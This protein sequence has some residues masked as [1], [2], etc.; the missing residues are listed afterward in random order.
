V[1]R[2][3]EVRVSF[4]GVQ[5]LGGVSL[6]AGAGA[7][8][9]LIGPNGA[10]KTTL[11]NVVTGFQ[12]PNRGSVSMD[13]RDITGLRPHVRARRGLG[14]TFQRL[15][16]FSS[17]SARENVLVG[18]EARH[19]RAEGDGDRHRAADEIL[20]RVGLRPVADRQADTLPTGMAR[21][22]ELGR[23][24]GTRPKVLLLDEPSSGL[25]HTE[26]ETLGRLL[27]GLA[28]E[29]M[30]VL[31]VEHD[32]DLVMRVCSRVHVLDFGQVI[33]VGTPAEVQADPR[34]QLAYLGAEAGPGGRP[35]GEAGPGG[36]PAGAAGTD[37]PAQDS[38]AGVGG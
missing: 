27:A 32:V 3:D 38:G 29:G 34:V 26:T 17:L 11:F 15:E 22:V 16:L 7:V 13:G 25:D 4:G 35:A 2:V 19:G 31:L 9:G 23:A 24:L 37:R 33:A 18:I 12:R 20:G 8:T 28:D 6:D 10:G 1:L 5:A 30:A 14:R 21:L 36:R